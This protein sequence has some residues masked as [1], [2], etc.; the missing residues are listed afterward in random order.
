MMMSPGIVGNANIS[1]SNSSKQQLAMASSIKW[2]RGRIKQLHTA[3]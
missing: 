1:S 3:I 2:E